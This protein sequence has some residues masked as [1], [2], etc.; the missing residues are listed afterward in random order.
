MFK[1]TKPVFWTERE[2]GFYDFQEKLVG[3]GWIF[4]VKP[5]K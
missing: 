3:A 2:S 5:L 4:C 1:L